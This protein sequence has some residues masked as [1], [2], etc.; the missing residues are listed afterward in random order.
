VDEGEVRG[1]EDVI[2]VVVVIPD[3]RWGELAFVNDVGGGEGADVEAGL[4]AA[5]FISARLYQVCARRH[6][7][8]M[9]S[10][11]AENVE[12]PEEESHIERRIL[13]LLSRAVVPLQNH[14]WLH[15]LWLLALRCGAENRV[16]RRNLSPAKH[17]QPES[18][19]HLLECGTLRRVV[20]G[21]EENVADRVL[22]LG[23]DGGGE[24]VDTLA[25]EEVV[26]D[27]GHHT[28][29]IPIAGIGASCEASVKTDRD[30][31]EDLLAPRWVMLQRMFLASLTILWEAC[32]LIW[33]MNPTPHI[34]RC[35]SQARGLLE[36]RSKPARCESIR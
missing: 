30:Q 26:R 36:G 1:I 4:K 19:R 28:S 5:I 18:L 22:P 29:T 20:L 3:L 7:H 34:L 31:V 24:R 16:V 6:S 10:L 8:P 32:P 25:D 21:R 23:G 35:G 17:S 15:S 12:L 13:T 11:L 33:Q 2:E 27:T 14:E 9:G